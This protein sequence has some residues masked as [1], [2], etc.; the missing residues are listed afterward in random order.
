MILPTKS[1]ADLLEILLEDEP[2]PDGVV[3]NLL[4]GIS[5]LGHGQDLVKDRLDSLLGSKLQHGVT[6][7]QPCRFTQYDRLTPP[8]WNRCG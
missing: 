8:S 7:Y 2:V 5:G 3:L 4:N 1:P 6:V